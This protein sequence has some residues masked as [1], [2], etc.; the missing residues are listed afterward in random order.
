MGTKQMLVPRHHMRNVSRLEN[1]HATTTHHHHHHY[2]QLPTT[3]RSTSQTTHWIATK[4]NEN[5]PRERDSSRQDIY[6]DPSN[7]HNRSER[8][9]NTAIAMKSC[10]FPAALLLLS[11]AQTNAF[12]GP[13]H[14]LAAKTSAASSSVLF[15]IELE[16]EPEGGEE[17]TAVK[18]MDGSRMKKMEEAEGVSSD[19]GTAYKFWLSAN[20]EGA[21]VKEIHTEVLKQSAKNANFPGFRKGQVVRATLCCWR[22]FWLF[23]IYRFETFGLT[24]FLSLLLCT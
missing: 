18:T 24:L 15:A 19:D 20:V 4:T 22:L 16:P 10:L 17:L 11:A 7:L 21:L 9:K 12:V 5:T 1:R 3:R 14:S 13:S 6:Q 23:V 8:K 2:S